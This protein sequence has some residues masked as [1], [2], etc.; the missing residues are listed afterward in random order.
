MTPGGGQVY[1]RLF[2]APFVL[3][4]GLQSDVIGYSYPVLLLAEILSSGYI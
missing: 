3:S 2:K 1:N 4:L